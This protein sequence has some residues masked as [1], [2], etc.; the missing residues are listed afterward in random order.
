MGNSNKTDN[1]IEISKAMIGCIGTVL[2][3]IIGGVFLLVS[4]GVIQ[5]S[6]SSPKVQSNASSTSPQPVEAD[7]ETSS[8]GAL[9]QATDT[10]TPKM[11]PNKQYNGWII[12][13]HGRDGYEYLIAYPENDAKQGVSLNFN[14]TNAQGHQVEVANDSLKMCYVNGEWYGYPDPSPWFPTVSYIKLLDNKILVCSDS[15]DCKG[16]QW[17]ML[18]EKYFPGNAPELQEP[19]EAGIHIIAYKPSS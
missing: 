10:P 14:L 2:A 5:I 6:V 8:E 1:T 16:D 7:Q 15:P 18:P 3:A 4:T 9:R 17:T 13:W 19:N 12:C 11:S